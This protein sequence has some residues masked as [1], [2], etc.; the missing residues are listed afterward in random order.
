M[1]K[2]QYSRALRAMLFSA[3]MTDKQVTRQRKQQ[4]KKTKQSLAKRRKCHDTVACINDALRVLDDLTYEATFTTFHLQDL[5]AGDAQVQ[6]DQGYPP[7]HGDPIPKVF[8][9][10]RKKLG[11]VKL[12]G[13]CPTCTESLY[14]GEQ[15]A[16]GTMRLRESLCHPEHFTNDI[17]E[18]DAA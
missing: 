6:A 2:L 4:K 15:Y 16:D 5:V 11:I 1:N 9:R 12:W 8:D 14:Y 13:V 3:D 18:E 17:T 7:Y 10:L